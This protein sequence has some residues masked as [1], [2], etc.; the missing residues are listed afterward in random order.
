WGVRP[1]V[2]AGHSIGELAAAHV[3]GLWSL[4]DAALIVSARGRLMQRLP[5]GGAMAAVQ[6]TEDE[7]LPVLPD[8]TGIAAVNGPVSVVVSGPEAGVDEVVRHFSEAGRKTKR[9]SVSHAFHSPL[10]EPM[11]AEFERIAAQLIYSEPS[12]PIVSTLTGTAVTYADLSEPSYWVRHVREAVRFA[13]AVATLDS[14][15]VR[16]FLELGPD[17]VLTAMAADT[18][19]EATL[20]ATLRRD[21]TEPHALVEALTRL[22]VVD[23]AAYFGPGRQDVDLPTYAF[24]HQPYWLD[25]YAGAVRGDVAGAGQSDAEHPLLGAAVELPDSDGV[26]FTGRLSLATHPWLAEHAVHGTVVVPGA[27]LVEIAVRAGDQVGAGTVRDLT[28]HAPLVL[29]EAGAVALRVRVG[30]GDEP[31]VT[32]HSRPEG[33]EGWTLHAEGVLSADA[34]E[35]AADLTAWPPAGAEPVDTTALY[36]DLAGVGLVY[37]SLFQGL[38]S[39]WRATDGTVYAEVTLPEGTDTEGFGIHP[40]LLDAALHTITLAEESDS[41][42]Q[43]PFSW[44]DVTLHATGAS[45]VR[46][47]VTG[48]GSGYRLDL[49]D[50]AGAPVATVGALALRPLAAEPSAVRDLYRVEWV[51]VTAR[52]TEPTAAYTVLRAATAAELLPRLQAHLSGDE[53]TLLVHTRQAATDPEQSAIRG[54]T[55]AAQAEHPDRIVLIDTP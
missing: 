37:G 1:D 12:I 4:E 22:P 19:T 54:L 50:P 21:R 48:E 42:A 29:P 8:G 26:L 24:Q 11:L 44:S 31:T 28:L 49:A 41:A 30:G 23:W 18:G 55:R 40:A 14:R 10:M 34:V 45:A 51:P 9:L 36:D 52:A 16:T 3:A 17:A 13:D 39:A 35:P 2:L 20:V 27:A 46:V 47:R 7:V 6:A 32:V 5:A 33:E 53:E 15:G 25:A 43:L 38:T